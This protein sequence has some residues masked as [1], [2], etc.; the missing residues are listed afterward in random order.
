MRFII[1]DE[2]G[3]LRALIDKIKDEG[4]D[5]AYY[6]KWKSDIIKLKPDILVA[7]TF[8]PLHHLDHVLIGLTQPLCN[9][10]TD[11]EYM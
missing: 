8:K 4:F 1:I 11:N 10:I 6:P 7:N 5:A 9:I 3:Y 2:F